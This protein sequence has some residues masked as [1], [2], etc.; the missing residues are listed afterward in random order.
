MTCQSSLKIQLTLHWRRNENDFLVLVLLSGL[1]QGLWIHGI[2][3]EEVC[4][5]GRVSLTSI[6]TL[7]EMLRFDLAALELE[8]EPAD[9]CDA[10]PLFS[11]SRSPQLL[12]AGPIA[13]LPPLPPTPVDDPPPPP[14]PPLELYMLFMIG[15]NLA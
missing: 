11:S 2:A 3:I 4:V 13:A 9:C 6:L 15:S 5:A 1:P 8:F 7:V 14:Q 10:L 12:P